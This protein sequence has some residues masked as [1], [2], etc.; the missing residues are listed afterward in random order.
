M[1]GEVRPNSQQVQIF[2]DKRGI[3]LQTEEV[4]FEMKLFDL[5]IVGIVDDLMNYLCSK[6]GRTGYYTHRYLGG[7]IPHF[8]SSVLSIIPLG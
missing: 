5:L 7:A 2:A 8:S 3:F 4:F 1:T 6:A